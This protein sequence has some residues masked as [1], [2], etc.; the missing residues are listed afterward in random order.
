MCFES[1]VRKFSLSQI[2]ID[3]IVYFLLKVKKFF[4]FTF[5]SWRH[6]IFC[7][8]RISKADNQLSQKY[9]VNNSSF[10][11]LCFIIPLCHISFLYMG[12]F[13]SGFSILSVLKSI[14]HSLK[15]IVLL[16]LPFVFF[17]LHLRR[18]DVPR[19]GFES[20]L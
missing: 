2:H 19:L 16:L 9:V 5:R 17:G 8:V 3:I 10:F 6:L 4:F 12:A 11:P 1:W 14:S 7:E 13:I 15:V 18:M 20:E